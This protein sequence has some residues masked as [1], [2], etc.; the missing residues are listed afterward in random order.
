MEIRQLSIEDAYRALNNIV[1]VVTVIADG[2]GSLCVEH[3]DAQDAIEEFLDSTTWK[4]LD[5]DDLAG[6]YPRV[7]VAPDDQLDCH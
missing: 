3:K 1:G 4:I 6:Q 5:A 2:P 7:Y